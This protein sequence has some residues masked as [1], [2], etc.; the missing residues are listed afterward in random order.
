MPDAGAF[1]GVLGVVLGIALVELLDGRRL[2]FDIEVI[3]FSE[4]EGVRFGVPFIGSRAFCGTLPTSVLDR[5]DAAGQRVRDAI[6]D[7]G[8]DPSRIQD[9]RFTGRALGYL[10]L[11]IEQGPV[12][13]SLDL[14][15]A[16]CRRRSPARAAWTS[17]FSGAAGHAGTTPMRTRRDALAGAA[18]WIVAVEQLAAATPGLVA[19]VGRLAV[20]PGASN[21]VPG[22]CQATLD[23]R[24]PDDRQRA[25][26]VAQ[27]IAAA[28]AIGA[29][30]GLE[31]D[32][33]PRLDQ[34]AVPMD[35]ALAGKVERSVGLAGFP[36]HRMD[37]GAGHDAMVV[38]DAMPAAMLLLRSP[39]A[40][41]HHPAEA[42]IEQDVA[43]ALVV[44]RHCLDEVAKGA[45][46]PS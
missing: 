3:G 15:L 45:P 37:C 17:R 41:S 13:E 44:A 39:G 42:V 23:A 26:G 21:V 28:Q 35:R 6:A 33:V 9:A 18:E 38:A 12:L 19:T 14:P 29:R 4:E 1:D 27:L 36:V 30:R 25:D 32:C 10:E 22:R 5:T 11:H 24:H 46:W 8:L 31:I 2:P 34:P 16:R 40:V 43:A 20:A 7:Y